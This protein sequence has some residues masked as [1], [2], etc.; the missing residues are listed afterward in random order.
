MTSVTERVQRRSKIGIRTMFRAASAVIN[1]S[2]A[3]RPAMA[4]DAAAIARV[5]IDSWRATYRG[6]I[7]DGYLDGMTLEDSTAIWHRVLSAGPNQTNTF[8]A[9]HDGVVTGFSS[10]LMLAEPKHG[11]DAELSAIY[12][13]PGEQRSGIGRQLLGAVTAAQRGLGATGLIVWVLAGN[14]KARG[15]YEHFGAELVLEQPFQWDGM[16]LVE[17][18]YG[19]RDLDALLARTGPTNMQQH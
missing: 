14:R 6:I 2:S 5:R 13:V 16:D 12:V 7:P 9:E 17:T 8:V 4:D 11:F 15:F 19:W 1:S 3:L 10:G 18:A